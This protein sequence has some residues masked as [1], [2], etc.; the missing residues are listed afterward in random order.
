[1][2]NNSITVIGNI[3]SL[4]LGMF[5][6]YIIFDFMRRFNRRLHYNKFIYIVAYGMFTLALFISTI[7]SN[8]IVNLIITI[9]GTLLIGHF[10]Y[11]NKK[12]YILYYSIFIMM[13]YAF[14]I[15]VS[16]VFN[17]VCMY[18]NITFYS[19]EVYGI[20]LSTIIQFANLGASR[21]FIICFKNRNIK[22]I[23]KS[24]YLNF[25]ILPLFSILYIT[26]LLMYIQMYMSIGDII[27]FIVNVVFIIILNLFITN[28][29]E[30]ISKNNELKH[31]VKLYEQQASMQYYYYNDLE[32]KYNSSRKLI[33]DIKNHLSTIEELYKINE[34]D[35]AKKYTDD[36]YLMMDRL[37]QKI[38]TS[39]RV[40]NIIINDKYEKALSFNIYLTCKIGDVN[41]DFIKDIDLTTIFSNLLD[42]AIEGST[43]F[44]GDKVINLKIDKFNN[45]IVVNIINNIGHVPIKNDK[46]FKST[47]K[48]HNG[49]GLQNVKIALEKY[50]GNMRI[51]YN[52]DCFKVNIVIPIII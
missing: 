19:I 47:K 10:L 48:D 4:F 49:F 28:I 46:L 44:T 41:L 15:I 6:T 32:N 27:L 18:F 36:I 29:F 37:A 2:I 45:F 5:S 31:E 33:H 30:S 38:Y 40:L 7:F 39:N 23:N 16:T 34:I 13:L 50:E 42:N 14:Q 8:G 43:N 22:T 24:Q 25:L 11:N 12:I 3:L 51:D 52:E 35:K 1:M 26:T 21:F 20:A 9:V 17:I